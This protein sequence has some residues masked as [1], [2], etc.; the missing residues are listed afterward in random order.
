MTRDWAQKD[1]VDVRT[2]GVSERR[3]LDRI[4]VMRPVTLRSSNRSEFTGVCTDVNL[5]GIGLET[6]YV[7]K[8]GQRVELEL[9]SADARKQCVPMMVIYRMGKHYGLS[10]IAPLDELVQLLTDHA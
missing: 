1:D 9:T 6:D 2:A 4:T 3:H 10:A 5:G 8:V 7:L